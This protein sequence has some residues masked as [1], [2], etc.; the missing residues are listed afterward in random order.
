[1]MKT[2][3]NG[4]Y[5][6]TIAPDGAILVKPGDWLSKYSVAIQNDWWH[7][8]EYG[9]KKSGNG[10]VDMIMNADLIHAGETLYHLPTYRNSRNP[11]EA[12]VPPAEPGLPLIND[13][14]KKRITIEALKRTYKIPG[15]NLQALSKAIDI[16]GYTENALTLIE[17]A[18]LIAEGGVIA[19]AGTALSLAGII[20]TPIAG[21]IQL[22]NDWETGERMYGMRGI[23]YATTA[24]AFGD[25]V[26]LSSARVLSNIRMDR[27][28]VSPYERA[29]RQ[30]A[31]SAV[32]ELEKEGSKR[33]NSAGTA[34]RRK[35]FQV[36][37]QAVGNGNSRETCLTLMKGFE[38]EWKGALLMAWQPNYG[39]TYP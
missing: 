33:S 32:H 28:D 17:V 2:Y 8:Y 3:R 16:L 13:A 19:S 23:C 21:I 25:S 27:A 31:R 34:Q 9:R 24:W 6:V 37:L 36:A 18:G 26:P 38:K 35:A 11:V 1:M 4:W 22:L 14:E 7:I 5:S 20:L 30:C 12:F 39:I 15:E 10:L 29:W